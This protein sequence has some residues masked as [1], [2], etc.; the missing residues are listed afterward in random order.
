M[1]SSSYDRVINPCILRFHPIANFDK[2]FCHTGQQASRK[3]LC[4]VVFGADTT[5]VEGN[6]WA[7]VYAYEIVYVC[8]RVT[9][10]RPAAVCA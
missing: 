5:T 7:L 3:E 6:R 8:F 9:G 1:C 2:Y 4:S 10:T